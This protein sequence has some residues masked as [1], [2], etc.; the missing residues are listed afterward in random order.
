MAITWWSRPIRR[1]LIG[2]LGATALVVAGV[3]LYVYLERVRTL[4]EGRAAAGRLAHVLEEQAARAF[5]GV[6]LTLLG[7]ADA[8]A[9]A[10]RLAANNSAFEDA[11]RRRLT[12]LP[13]VRGLFVIGADGFVTQETNQPQTPRRSRGERG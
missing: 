10:P 13:F 7:I 4:D 3:A 12:H 9:V 1:A 5:H 2:T 11:L 8:I 6:D